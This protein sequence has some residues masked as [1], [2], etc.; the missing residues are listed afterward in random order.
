[1][2]EN[3]FGFGVGGVEFGVLEHSIFMIPCSSVH[4]SS[5][6]SSGSVREIAKNRRRKTK[7]KRSDIEG[8]TKELF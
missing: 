1:M 4:I 8:I 2:V 5:R 6:L 7:E 3:G